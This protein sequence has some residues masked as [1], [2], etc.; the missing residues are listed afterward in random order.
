LSPSTLERLEEEN[1]M[2]LEGKDKLQKNK[3]NDRK[4]KGTPT[5]IAAVFSFIIVGV[6]FAF[7]SLYPHFIG[8]FTNVITPM[9][10]SGA[11]FSALRCLKRYSY[12]PRGAFDRIW[13]Y[14]AVG[15]GSWGVAQVFWS[16]SYFRGVTVPYPSV[17]SFDFFYIF[18]YMPML[19]ALV[20]YYRTFRAG[21]T[22]RKLILSGSGILVSGLFIIPILLSTEFSKIEPVAT[23]VTNLISCSLELLP[24]SLAILCLV[25]FS[26]GSLGRWWMF[27]VAGVILHVAE[28]LVFFYQ[29]S[30]GTYYNGSFSDYLLIAS[31][32]MFGLAFY[33][34]RKRL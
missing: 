29:S 26:G 12:S 19:A 5:Y 27:F 1:P 31:Y 7:Q 2:G 10:A 21:M 30:V 18:G 24:L 14:F 3:L 34:H 15:M 11:F 33:A 8:P 16:A 32:I 6:I 17:L 28:D 20:T 9:A 25:L 13:I 22:S 23:V 4:G